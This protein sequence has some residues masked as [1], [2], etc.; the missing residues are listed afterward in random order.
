MT[1]DG[2]F[3]TPVQALVDE[4]ETE[5]QKAFTIL[6][7]PGLCDHLQEHDLDGH[8]ALLMLEGLP[9]STSCAT[10]DS[11][12]SPL[13]ALLSPSSFHNQEDV[14]RNSEFSLASNQSPLSSDPHMENSRTSNESPDDSARLSDDVQ[15]LHEG[16]A[17]TTT[18]ATVTPTKRKVSLR[19]HRGRSRKSRPRLAR[20]ED[21]CADL[22]S[23]KDTINR[24]IHRMQAIIR[25][26]QRTKDINRSYDALRSIIPKIPLYRLSKLQVSMSFS[27]DQSKI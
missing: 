17:I 2:P 14:L 10:L 9:D 19:H 18:H 25:E 5:M 4:G 6:G 1:S 23:D 3:L 22:A 26:R 7:H 15:S 16:S 8:Y 27:G 12:H 21:S 11:G 13:T 24:E 20:A